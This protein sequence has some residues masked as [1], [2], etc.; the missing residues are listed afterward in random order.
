MKKLDFPCN[1]L[2]NMQI[3]VRLAVFLQASLGLELD[4]SS[5]FRDILGVCVHFP[6]KTMNWCDAQTYCSSIGG[7]LIRGKNFLPFNGTIFSG[8]PEFYWIGLTDFRIERGRNRSGWIW[9]DGSLEPTSVDLF[10]GAS[11]PTKANRDCAS[12]C[13]QSGK[14]CVFSCNV[15]ITPM[16]QVK[17]NSSLDDRHTSYEQ[18]AIPLGLSGNEFAQTEGCSRLLTQ[19]I[20]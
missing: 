10:W 3:A 7:E 17:S 6:N 11:H 19:V 18:A 4:C 5:P 16:C 13:W 15:D 20:S 1:F 2:F 12:T 14:I 8:M 9:T